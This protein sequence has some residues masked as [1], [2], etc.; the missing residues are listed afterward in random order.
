[1][2]SSEF[3]ASGS[4]E[5][6]WGGR[7]FP[8]DSVWLASQP[9]IRVV[10]TD[11]PK[12][13]SG[14]L[15]K[16]LNEDPTIVLYKSDGAARKRFT[17]APEL[18]YYVSRVNRGEIEYSYVALRAQ[19]KR[20]ARTATKFFANRFAAALLLPETVVR[21]QLK[22]KNKEVFLMTPFFGVSAEIICYRLKALK[23]I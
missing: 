10:E 8:V 5:S 3:V 13:V 1:M 22:E 19:Q 11:L 9:G 17:C 14:A 4:L 16:E 2:G 18:G 6:I 23:L 21:Q 7:G 15:I 12:G 20:L